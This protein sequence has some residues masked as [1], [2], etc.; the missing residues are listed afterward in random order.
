MTFSECQNASSTPAGKGL[1]I[2]EGGREHT[3]AMVNIDVDVEYS[4]EAALQP[5]N[6]QHYVIA[7]T[8]ARGR[9]SG[10]PVGKELN[11]SQH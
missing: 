9:I 1:N 4:T 7:V 2:S 11:S 8:V 10:E 6:S 5:Q 3:V